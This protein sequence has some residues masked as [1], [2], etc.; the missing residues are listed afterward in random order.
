MW[1][2]YMKFGIFYGIT[3]NP[4]LMNRAKVPVDLENARKLANIAF[5]APYSIKCFMIQTWGDDVKSMVANGLKIAK[6]SKNVVVKV[7]LTKEGIEAAAELRKE[8]KN[9]QEVALE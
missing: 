6:I 8:G 1:N 2:K 4:V 7:P 9:D 3:T 5:N